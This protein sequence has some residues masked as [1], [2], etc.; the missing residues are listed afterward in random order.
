MSGRTDNQT[1]SVLAGGGSFGAA[2][3]GVLRA[4][5]H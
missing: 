2:Q 4:P 5:E 1:A 3:V